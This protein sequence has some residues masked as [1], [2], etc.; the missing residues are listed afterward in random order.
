MEQSP[1]SEPDSHS[2]SEE[3]P[4]LLWNP[5]VHYRVHKSPPLLPIL[6]QMNPVHIHQPYF[7]KIHSNIIL[8][9]TPRTSTSSL[10][11]RFFGQ[12]FVCIS[13]LSNACYMHRQSHPHWVDHPNNILWSVQVMILLILYSLLQPPATFSLLGPDFVLGA[14]F[15]HTVYHSNRPLY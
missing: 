1:S 2:T 3:I 15:L 5:K 12:H 13:H 7:S 10:R 9:S 8:L 11:L 4:R 14:V 6:I